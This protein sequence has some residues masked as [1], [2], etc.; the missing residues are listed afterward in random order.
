M[1]DSRILKRLSP[2]ACS[3]ILGSRF[4][5]FLASVAIIVAFWVLRASARVAEVRK[6]VQVPNK[7]LAAGRG[8]AAR[9]LLFDKLF[10]LLLCMSCIIDSE[11]RGLWES[12][13][14]TEP[15]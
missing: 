2:L 10:L 13:N 9:E 11:C 3:K 15:E 14:S 7:N 5:F 4:S 12:P 8:L 1:C 6:L